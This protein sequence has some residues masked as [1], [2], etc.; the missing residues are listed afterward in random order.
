M[1]CRYCGNK[2]P[3]DSIFCQKCGKKL[4][5]SSSVTDTAAT[6]KTTT[7]QTEPE[8]NNATANNIQDPSDYANHKYTFSAQK[9]PE[10]AAYTIIAENVP[11]QDSTLREKPSIYEIDAPIP[12]QFAPKEKHSPKLARLAIILSSIALAVFLLFFIF[13][14]PGYNITKIISYTVGLTIAIGLYVTSLIFLLRSRPVMLS[15]VVIWT[16]SILCALC[17]I[18]TGVYLIKVDRVTSQVAY[19]EYTNVK[20]EID[21]Q[22]FSRLN[23]GTVISPY[24]YI[25]IGSQKYSDGDVL[26][27]LPNYTYYGAIHCGHSQ[28]EGRASIEITLPSS[29]LKNG[30]KIQTKVDVGSTQYAEVTLTFTRTVDFWTVIFD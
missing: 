14:S 26:Y 22:Y 3:D 18:L 24:A 25:K 29:E 10:G 23:K 1:F 2:I 8:I 6:T 9:K 30:H 4:T 15:K 28:N 21:Y 20:L 5:V 7:A 13:A 17:V 12:K 16:S 11:I 19:D 27:I